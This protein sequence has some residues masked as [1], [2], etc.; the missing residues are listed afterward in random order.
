MFSPKFGAHTIMPCG[1]LM[2][3]GTA[4]PIAPMSAI[5]TP[6]LAAAARAASA[7]R[8]TV[9]FAP[10]LALELFS[11]RSSSFS[12]WSTTAARTFVPP[13]SMPMTYF[14]PARA[15]ARFVLK[16]SSG[17]L[18]LRPMGRKRRGVHR[19][20]RHAVLD[21]GALHVLVFRGGAGLHAV[22]PA[23]LD[24]YGAVRCHHGQP[25]PLQSVPLHCPVPDAECA[26]LGE[27][28]RRQLLGLLRPRDD[29]EQRRRPALL[30]LN[31]REEH[32]QRASREQPFDRN[33][34][35][36]RRQ[37]VQVRFEHRYGPR[38]SV[39]DPNGFVPIR[40]LPRLADA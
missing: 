20:R 29:G 33:L 26:G 5:F 34:K 18:F 9:C 22:P 28:D 30:H 31:R 7:M 13:R 19:L 27:D 17:Y 16:V 38:R 24:P 6:E 3:P 14:A 40:A 8:A 25:F 39:G 11:A 2:W 35:Q 10:D 23:G 1:T 21:C 37:V 32:V 12:S 36:L 4:T 15:A